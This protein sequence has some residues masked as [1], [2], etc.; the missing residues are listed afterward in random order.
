MIKRKGYVALVKGCLEKGL[1][2]N[3]GTQDIEV[4]FS[5]NAE[6]HITNDYKKINVQGSKGII[7]EY[8]N[9]YNLTHKKQV[10]FEI[11]KVCIVCDNNYK[12]MNLL[13]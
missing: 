11:H 13:D 10:E 2:I 9:N 7:K 8:I 1:S 4:W 5:H 12:T 6:Y 3:N